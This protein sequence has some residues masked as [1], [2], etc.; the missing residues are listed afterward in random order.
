MESRK[1][2]VRIISSLD[3]NQPERHQYIHDSLELREI[4]R[5]IEDNKKTKD[6]IVPANLPDNDIKLLKALIVV[7]F[8]SSPDVTREKLA[9]GINIDGINYVRYKRTASAAKSG[10]CFF[11]ANDAINKKGKTL[12]DFMHEWSLAGFEETTKFQNPVS[13]EAYSALTL[14]EI[15]G[16]FD[17]PIE[18]ILI[19]PDINVTLK[20]PESVVRV[21]SENNQLY[22][23]D[24]N[25]TITNTIWD[26]E[27]LLDESVFEGLNDFSKKHMLLLRS[28]FFKSCVFKTKLQ[29]WFADNHITSVDQLTSKGVTLA[30]DIHDIKL[31]ITE[32]SLK[33]LKFVTADN[34][35]NTLNKGFLQWIDNAKSTLKASAGKITFGVVKTDNPSKFMNGQMNQTSYQLI[36]TLGLDKKQVEDL[37]SPA[38]DF[39]GKLKSDPA[40]VRYYLDHSFFKE[41]AKDSDE[42][43]SEAQDTIS[44][45]NNPDFNLV[46]YYPY[47]VKQ[48]LG[49]SNDFADTEIYKNAVRE[50]ITEGFRKR[51]LHGKTLIDGVFATIFG[52]GA[53]LLY[54]L[55]YDDYV[56][57]QPMHID[58]DGQSTELIVPIGNEIRTSRFETSNEL[59]CMRYPHITMGNFIYAKNVSSNFYD[60]YFD[61]SNEIVCVDSIRSN[62]M[63]TLNGCD[64]DSDFM[65]IT[66]NTIL[67][68]VLKKQ[69]DDFNRLRSPYVDI[70]NKVIH[71]PST[72]AEYQSYI[73]EADRK[74]SNNLI[75]KIVNLSQI[76]N[77]LFWMHSHLKTW[78]WNHMRWSATQEQIYLRSCILA[79]LSNVE[80]DS[81]K[82]EF[83]CDVSK[84][85]KRLK[86]ELPYF[87]PYGNIDFALSWFEDQNKMS[88]FPKKDV[89]AHHNKKEMLNFLE[90]IKKYNDN[91][92]ELEKQKKGPVTY[93]SS[94]T[95]FISPDD[96]LHAKEIKLYNSYDDKFYT[97]PGNYEFFLVMNLMQCAIN[98]EY[99]KP[100]KPKSPWGRQKYI[101]TAK[102]EERI[103]LGMNEKSNKEVR[104]EELGAMYM[105]PLAYVESSITDTS[106]QPIKKRTLLSLIDTDSIVLTSNDLTRAVEIWNT[107]NDYSIK[108]NIIK[109]KSKG[110]V[111]EDELRPETILTKECFEYV[112]KKVTAPALAE[113]LYMIDCNIA[114]KDELQKSLNEKYN[115]FYQKKREKKFLSKNSDIDK[116]DKVVYHK[117]LRE[118]I[119]TLKSELSVLNNDA[120]RLRSFNALLFSSLVLGTKPGKKYSLFTTLVMN[121]ELAEGHQIEKLMF[122]ENG[123]IEVYGYRFKKE[124]N[125]YGSTK[126]I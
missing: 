77:S 19:V 95:P 92:E 36:N 57:G 50:N 90:G 108:I 86:S 67:T 38:R 115:A 124:E 65:L 13:W 41:E 60:K 103:K 116:K 76:Y 30:K 34:K 83:T 29:K 48:L 6:Y 35:E 80:I 119:A 70:K 72:D 27:G 10:H 61:L 11:I 7:D 107:V 54:S 43:I 52:N 4:L 123:D 82:R 75:G 63:N 73:F 8:S 101:I 91:F 62:I 25:V 94:H 31:V 66:D 88:Y 84:E 22:A 20:E 78:D 81:A 3:N 87:Y 109:A 14:S 37:Y 59:L 121:K 9:A 114:E 21:Y 45:E 32:S 5:K 106:K 12:F 89:H 74:I 42:N 97:R 53:E 96:E 55:I 126:N 2:V 125:K 44:D 40:Y 100:T 17:L 23:K 68:N 104:K 56:P 39:L 118:D 15:K 112:G 58:K 98:L 122:D 79:A 1:Y 99:I 105:T 117:E 85:Y 113:L 69:S 33:Y 16:S 64:F 110:N 24:D 102:G 51:L 93:I 47:A 111:S 18:S 120:R 28:K 46:N 49:I 71:T 26:G